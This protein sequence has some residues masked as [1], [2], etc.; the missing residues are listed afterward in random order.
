MQ[1]RL[2]ANSP[3]FVSAGL[4]LSPLHLSHRCIYVKRMY[5]QLKMARRGRHSDSSGSEDGRRRE[6]R[7]HP[8]TDSDEGH[9]KT[10][11]D[12]DRG[13]ESEGSQK[14]EA[15]HD[16]KRRKERSDTDSREK[17]S[18]RRDEKRDHGSRRSGRDSKID[19]DKRSKRVE[20]TTKE[21]GQK[22]RKDDRDMDRKLRHNEGNDDEDHREVKPRRN[23]DYGNEIDKT[24]HKETDRVRQCHSYEDLKAISAEEVNMGVRM[25]IQKSAGEVIIPVRMVMRWRRRRGSTEWRRVV[26]TIMTIERMVGK[27][28]EEIKSKKEKR[29]ARRVVISMAGEVRR[30]GKRVKL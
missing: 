16:R 1:H 29:G 3:H 23:R 13:S 7:R 14:E 27:I 21:N 24:I 15:R 25:M 4:L 22:S 12:L 6:T 10:R 9:M 20:E 17:G 5:S 2:A 19:D 28:G 26:L 8:Y 11:R 18:G 30:I